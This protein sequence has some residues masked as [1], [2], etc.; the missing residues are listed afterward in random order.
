[1][2]GFLKVEYLNTTKQMYKDKGRFKEHI[3][4][5]NLHRKIKRVVP[6]PKLKDVGVKV[7]VRRILIVEL[8]L[9]LQQLIKVSVGSVKVLVVA[10]RHRRHMIP[11]QMH[12]ARSAGLSKKDFTNFYK[13]LN[14]MC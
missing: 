1:M 11:H 2:N 8:A 3:R 5:N 6:R 7:V 10:L 9:L 4:I 12:H 14:F 13:K